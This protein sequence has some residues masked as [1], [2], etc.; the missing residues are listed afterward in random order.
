MRTHPS[1]LLSSLSMHPAAVAGARCVGAAALWP[2]AEASLCSRAARWRDCTS[3]S[4]AWPSPPGGCS[5][6][7]GLLAQLCATL[8]GRCRNG[9]ASLSSLTRSGSTPAGHKGAWPLPVAAAHSS[10]WAH[11][12]ACASSGAWLWLLPAAVAMRLSPI[13]TRDCVPLSRRSLVSRAATARAPRPQRSA[14]P[15]VAMRT[16]T[17]RSLGFR[18]VLPL[19]GCSL[20]VL[21]YNHGSHALAR[22]ERRALLLRG[23]SLITLR[24]CSLTQPR[25]TCLA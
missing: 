24:G 6:C 18:C 23:C 4:C 13:H 21:S 17:H 15:C 5:L 11:T 12:P 16:H 3:L 20:R 8:G 10:L 19:S 25:P 14:V 9:C 22:T 7:A 1:L 2:S